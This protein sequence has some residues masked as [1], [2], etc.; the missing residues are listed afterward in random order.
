MFWKTQKETQS[1]EGTDLRKQTTT[2]ATK[3]LRII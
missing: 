3:V 2:I 1:Q